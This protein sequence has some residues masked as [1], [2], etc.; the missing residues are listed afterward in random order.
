MSEEGN[1]EIPE[2]REIPATAR[3][4]TARVKGFVRPNCSTTFWLC[5]PVCCKRYFKYDTH[6]E[7]FSRWCE[8][9]QNSMESATEL[10]EHA[11]KYHAKNYCSECNNVYVNLK[12]HKTS[13][14]PDP[15]TKKRNSRMPKNKV[16][17]T[18]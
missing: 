12:G 18:E 13:E 4:P 15:S 3:R 17:Q 1:D 11:K 9:C 5:C 14:H 10:A 2:D 6:F 7:C 8:L 16:D